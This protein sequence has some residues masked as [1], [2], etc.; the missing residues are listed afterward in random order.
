M[1]H[2]LRFSSKGEL[3]CQFSVEYSDYERIDAIELRRYVDE[4]HRRIILLNECWRGFC[5]MRGGNHIHAASFSLEGG[6][7]Q[8]ESIYQFKKEPN[9]L[10][11]HL[12]ELVVVRKDGDLELRDGIQIQKKKTNWLRWRIHKGVPTPERSLAFRR[13]LSRTFISGTYGTPTKTT[14]EPSLKNWFEVQETEAGTATREIFVSGHD[15]YHY[16][17]GKVRCLDARRWLPN[18]SSDETT[19]KQHCFRLVL[20]PSGQAV[21]ARDPNDRHF[22][23]PLHHWQVIGGR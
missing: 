7:K 23:E 3:L 16:S 15:L 13:S 8:W 22:N 17:S 21:M 20:T 10:A 9:W 4:N 14:L 1:Q 12:P 5:T 6:R 18:Q 19:H 11:G 2:A